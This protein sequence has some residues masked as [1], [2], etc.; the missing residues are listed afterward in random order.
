MNRDCPSLLPQFCTWMRC[1]IFRCTSLNF[2]SPLDRAALEN[3]TC[4]NFEPRSSDFRC[5][6]PRALQRKRR[7]PDHNDARHSRGR[8][9]Q[10]W[11]PL[12]P[13]Y[14]RRRRIHHAACFVSGVRPNG[15]N[16]AGRHR[17]IFSSIRNADG[18]AYP[19]RCEA[20]SHG[21]STSSRPD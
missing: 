8:D 19:L 2:R 6:S 21:D 13:P 10:Y 9:C 16:N 15:W 18:S 20:G 7:F 1:H 3:A 12:Y 11:T 17:R 4:E 14:R 5:R